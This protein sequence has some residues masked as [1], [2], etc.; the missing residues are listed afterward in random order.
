MK[1]FDF[2]RSS[3]CPRGP[4]VCRRVLSISSPLSLVKR[5][6]CGVLSVLCV[7]CLVF[8]FQ[9]SEI[10]KVLLRTLIFGPPVEVVTD[11]REM[12]MF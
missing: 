3:K 11:N 6:L 4:P 9:I 8:V 1:V 2:K 10:K 7:S 12:N 5:S